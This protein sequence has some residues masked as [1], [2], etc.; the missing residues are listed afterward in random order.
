MTKAVVVFGGSGFVGTH[1]VRRLSA[2]GE[3]VISVDI[4][5]PRE[6]LAG[7]DYL[8]GDVRDLHDIKLDGNVNRI[9]NL[10]AI[11]TTPGHKTH[12][13]YE[14]NVL[15]ALEVT[16]FASMNS[17]P[18]IVFTSSISV[19]GPGEDMK[20]EQTSPAPESAYGYSKL[21]AE[22]IHEQW[23]EAGPSRK[24]VITRPAVVFGP[25]ERG[26]FSRLAS[27][28]KRGLFVYPGR[29]DTIKA[30]IYIDDLLDAIEFARTKDSNYKLFNASYPIQYRLNEI[31][32][33]LVRS[34][35]PGARTFRLPRI[36]VILT[37]RLLKAF[38]LFDVGIHPDRVMKLV[39]STNVYP[40]WLLSQG[41]VFPPNIED[42][43]ARW[44]KQSNNTFE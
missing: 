15:G 20:T 31:V 42:T 26:N 1:L 12:E 14:T 8:N 28:L 3:K 43:F 5:Q 9:Y 13:Y 32:D 36:A 35:F 2:A 18:E 21:I 25:G 37:A 6:N 41:W 29:T 7:V 22:R 34:H 4:R 33:A 24:L 44:A 19:Y 10:A 17:I 39:R 30:C 16:R 40:G 23:L 27:L 38:N 11:H